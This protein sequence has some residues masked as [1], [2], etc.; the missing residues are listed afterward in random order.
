MRRKKGTRVNGPYSR[1]GGKRWVV[2]ILTEDGKPIDRSFET[3]AEASRETERAAAELTGETEQTVSLAIDAYEKYQTAKGNK[4]RTVMDTIWRLHKF[5]ASHLSRAL[6]RVTTADCQAAYRALTVKWSPD[7][8][9]N[10]LA[11]AKTWGRWVVKQGWWRVSPLEGV[12]G[13]GARSTG[14]EQLRHDESRKFLDAC[15]S[16]GLD[17]EPGRVAAMTALIMG[18]RAGEIVTRQVRDLDNDGRLLWIPCSKTKAGKRTLVIPEV[19]RPFLL[20]Q[21]R[22][23]LPMANLF[24]FTSQRIRHWSRKICLEAGVPYVCAH[25]L[26]GTNA[27]L[28]LD[29]GMAPLEVA[30]SLGHASI[31]MTTKVYAVPGAGQGVA[32]E[33]GAAILR[34]NFATTPVAAAETGEEVE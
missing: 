22:G 14:K 19:L 26:R 21:A 23:K 13:E 2:R 27:S 32:V 1:D 9:R 7:S 15:L 31:E 3:E 24:N 29:G 30:R 12:E 17:A 4:P 5:M 10:A 6:P 34:H 11:G 25:G 16:R 33:R 8:H 18:M 20:R 28:A